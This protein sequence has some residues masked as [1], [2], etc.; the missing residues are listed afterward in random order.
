[1]LKSAKK[2]GNKVRRIVIT[3]SYASVVDSSAK[4]VTTFTEADWNETSPKVL[5][6][7]GNDCPPIEVYRSSKTLAER[8]AWKFIEEEK[9]QFD[10]ATVMPPFVLGP[11]IH[12]CKKPDALNTSVAGW[13]AYLSGKKG[14]EG[15]DGP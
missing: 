14:G 15:A 8:A 10:I 4:P 13:Y 9:P 12:Q 7:K 2:H 1:M 6:E 3:S 11:I 5:K